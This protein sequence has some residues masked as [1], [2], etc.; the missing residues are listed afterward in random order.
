MS[1]V[2]LSVFRISPCRVD[3]WRGVV[4]GKS[5]PLSPPRSRS[6]SFYKAIAEAGGVRM[7]GVSG[8]GPPCQSREENRAK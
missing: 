7:S 1:K 3:M 4:E 5:P 8:L 6:T 2:R